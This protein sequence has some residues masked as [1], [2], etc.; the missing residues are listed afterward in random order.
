[1]TIKTSMTLYVFPDEKQ[2]IAD[3]LEKQIEDYQNDPDRRLSPRPTLSQFVIQAATNRAREILGA[4][5][6]GK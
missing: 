3:A 6:G 5:E 2:V 4:K 1:M